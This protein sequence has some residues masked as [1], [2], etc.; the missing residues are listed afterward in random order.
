MDPSFPGSSSRGTVGLKKTREAMDGSRASSAGY[1]T[2]KQA[3]SSCLRIV[4]YFPPLA[5][6]GFDFKT[7]KIVACF[8]G[9]RRSK[10]KLRNNKEVVFKQLVQGPR[11]VAGISSDSHPG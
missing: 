9:G 5:F 8:P 10:W 2:K 3:A 1:Q 6:K 7:G 11:C 4:V